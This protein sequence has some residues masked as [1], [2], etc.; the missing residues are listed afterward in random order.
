MGQM[1]V[2]Q[3]GGS[4]SRKE[5]GLGIVK[6]F[7]GILILWTL[8]GMLSKVAFLLI[9]GSL[10][11]EATLADFLNV[12]WAGLRL[13][14][15]IA[16]YL[17][18][19]PAL[20]L[21]VRLWWQGRALRWLWQGYF[22][23]TSFVASL[24]YVANLA[25][26]GYWGFPLDNTPLLYLKTSP[27][28]AF[29][30][31]NAWQMVFLPLLI[32]ALTVGIYLAFSFV[33]RRCLPSD[34]AEC[35]VMDS[36][37]SAS[38]RAKLAYSLIMLLLTALLIIPIRG[39]FGTGT[40]H[41]G[42][43]Y[44]STSIRLNHAAVNPLF[45]FVESV[46]HQQE[47]GTK[48]RFM[49][50]EQADREFA[51]LTYTALRADARRSNCNVVLICL[52]GFSK[53]IMSEKGH[54]EGITP[55]LD[56]L[57]REGLYF[58]RVYANS[59]RTDRALV[60][61]LSA[62]PAQPTMS[63]MDLPRKST[64]LPSLASAL[65]RHGYSTTFYYGGDVNYSNMR[66]YLVGTGFQHIV[67]DADFPS[68]LHT[69]KWG[70]ADGPVYDRL[71][72]DIRQ[73]HAAG[74]EVPFLRVMMSES[75]HEPFDVP[76]QGGFESP[77]LNAFAY[78]DSCLGHFVDELQAL[79]C[80]QNTLLVIVPDHLGAYPRDIDNYALW[81]YEIPLV[82]LGGGVTAPE[83]EAENEPLMSGRRGRTVSVTGSQVD[84]VAT[85]L[86]ML[87]IAHDEF[88]YSKDL[89]DNRAPHFAFFTFPDAMGMVGDSCAVIHD[90]TSGQAVL[91]EGEGSEGLLLKSKAYLQK[92]YD[93]IDK[94]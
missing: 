61:I 60:S 6:L 48:Y 66:S 63:I 69:G 88:T 31:M 50:P 90:N 22:A 67:A 94:R 55:N 84:I 30:S 89:L 11:P 79:P 81:R 32:L 41:T 13:D 57:C 80:W 73:A 87:G 76:Y 9:Y 82:M 5:V 59:F 26:Y 34:K 18:L 85:I 15:A 53:Y 86:G 56:R 4:Q 2:G 23:L 42:S 16:G 20:M 7:F 47:I 39:G 72:A 45:C 29:A 44:F 12:V 19:L 70:V 36:S 35:G 21:I 78:A 93:D 91:Q 68:S 37:A 92:L 40:N 33:V 8:I 52:E 54:V 25:L 71:L 62:L 27:A 75:S 38:K 1:K 17:L 58:D 46:S 83:D 64:S 74:A 3:P 43:V 51:A 10:M 24:G 28:D 14:V 65:G 77:E 49:E